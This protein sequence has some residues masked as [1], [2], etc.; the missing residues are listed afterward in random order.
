MGSSTCHKRGE[1]EATDQSQEGSVT[2]DTLNKREG[3]ENGG[4]TFVSIFSPVS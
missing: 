1:G 4:V 3:V 2:K